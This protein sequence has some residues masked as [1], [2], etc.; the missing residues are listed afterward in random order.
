MKP[1]EQ[2]LSSF[3][4]SWDNFST[5]WKTGRSKASEKSI[6]NLRVS[7][8]RLIANLELMRSISRNAEIPKLQR[9]FKKVLKSMGT[10]RDVQVQLDKIEELRQAESIVDFR[11]SLENRERRQITNIPK[12]LKRDMKRRLNAGVKDVRSAMKGIYDKAGDARIKT[13]V[14][15]T[16]RSR[17]AEFLKARKHFKPE[18]EE[19]LHD[20]RIALKKLRYTIEAAQPLLGRS[21][22][23]QAQRMHAFQQLLGETRD[24]ELLRARLEKWAA[25][26][27]KTIAVVPALES[28]QEKRQALIKKIVES[29]AS[30]DDLFPE[31]Q[32]KPALEKTLAVE[33]TDDAI[34]RTR[35]AAVG[36]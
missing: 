28:L 6:H 20:M 17:R 3:D 35:V 14:D 25:K 15:R 31:E 32:L 23:Q 22:K 21:A 11:R 13:A 26:H 36:D 18:V 1:S 30:L 8:R 12:Q 24:F 4:T 29:V 19:T 7:T 2:L 16:L 10:L 9:R 5:S 34:S 33:S 27:G